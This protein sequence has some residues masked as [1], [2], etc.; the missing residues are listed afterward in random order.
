MA[1]RSATQGRDEAGSCSAIGNK[2]PYEFVVRSPALGGKIEITRY[3][4]NGF[5]FIL[6]KDWHRKRTILC[7]LELPLAYCSHF[8]IFQHGEYL[9][10]FAIAK[11]GLEKQ[12]EGLAEFSFEV[13]K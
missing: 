9:E 13:A 5:C 7:A 12:Q 11:S 1:Y 10:V 2:F 6:T 4:I 3:E 8:R